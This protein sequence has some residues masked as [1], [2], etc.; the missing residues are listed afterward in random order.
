MVSFGS[1]IT[2]TSLDDKKLFLKYTIKGV[3]DSAY[4]YGFGN[5]AIMA[6]IA[7]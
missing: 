5:C 3:R 4:I 2:F 7:F 1:G 6:D